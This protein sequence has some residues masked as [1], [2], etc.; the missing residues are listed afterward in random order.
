MK[1]S[2]IERNTATLKGKVIHGVFYKNIEEL[3]AEGCS[4]WLVKG[5]LQPSDEAKL[6]VAQDGTLKTNKYLREVL[7]TQVSP[8]CR[9]CKINGESVGH[10]LSHVTSTNSVY[11]RQ[12]TMKQNN[13]VKI[14]WNPVIVTTVNMTARRPDMMVFIKDTKTIVVVEQTCCWDARITKAFIEKWRKYHPL[15]ADLRIQFPT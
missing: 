11:T 12:D 9:L 1:N 2:Q 10:I 5:K 13:K 4:Q 8:M 7:G 15:I 14:L 6:I 3:G